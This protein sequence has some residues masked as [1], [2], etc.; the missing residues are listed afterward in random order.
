[1]ASGK[2]AATRLGSA[3][4]LSR[5]ARYKLCLRTQTERRLPGCASIL[6]VMATRTTRCPQEVT[7]GTAS[8]EN[9]GDRRHRA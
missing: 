9:A 1:M 5:V 7:V 3:R 4:W 6:G 8:F 2:F